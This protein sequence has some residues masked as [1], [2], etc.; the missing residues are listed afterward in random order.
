M[1][2]TS[3]RKVPIRLMFISER[4]ERVTERMLCKSGWDTRYGTYRKACVSSNLVFKVSCTSKV[5]PIASHMTS[6]RPKLLV[7]FWYDLPEE[8]KSHQL[9]LTYSF[10]WCSDWRYTQRTYS[11]IR[12]SHSGKPNYSY[13]SNWKG[14][15]KEF[16]LSLYTRESAFTTTEPSTTVYINSN[17]GRR[18]SKIYSIS[19]SYL[20]K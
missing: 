7:H 20:L 3:K 17:S 4:S 8:H 19:R 1:G 18:R 6:G 5:R 14:C 10:P 12:G 13:A 9:F 2:T 11:G 15:G 16:V